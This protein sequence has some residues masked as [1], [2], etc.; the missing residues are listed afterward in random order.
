MRRYLFLVIAMLFGTSAWSHGPHSFAR[1]EPTSQ[2][3]VVDDVKN[4]NVSL[5]LRSAAGEAVYL[6][7]CHS[8]V[9]SSDAD[10]A[11]SGDFECRLSSIGQRDEYSTLLTEDANQSRDW[12]SRARFF[13]RSLAGKC[14]DIPEFGAR[15]SFRLRRMRITLKI[16]DPQFDSHGELVALAL[17][18]DVKPDSKANREIA[19]Q[20]AFPADAPLDCEL[21]KYFVR[22]KAVNS[23]K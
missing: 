5:T 19:A 2:E 4:A 6:L 23:T 20:V 13:S 3:F 7:Q 17:R 9:Y 12:E 11:Y 1:I 8:A 15:R 10:F 22:S 16:M 21:D 14:A 18:V